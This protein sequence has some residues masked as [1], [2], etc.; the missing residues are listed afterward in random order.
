MRTELQQ[1][2]QTQSA[3][4]YSLCLLS[5]I[6]LGLCACMIYLRRKEAA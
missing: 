1:Q 3:L 6:N 2:Q 5:G 4:L